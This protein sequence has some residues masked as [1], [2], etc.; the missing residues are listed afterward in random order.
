MPTGEWSIGFYG[1][2]VTAGLIT[3]DLLQAA[4]RAG[5]IF[6]APFLPKVAA[7]SWLVRRGVAL[8]F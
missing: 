2:I 3:T 5:R 7:P 6:S 4:A 8:L 1:T